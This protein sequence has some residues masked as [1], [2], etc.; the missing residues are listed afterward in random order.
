MRKVNVISKPN[1]IL[2]N[3]N[4]ISWYSKNYIFL[5][6]VEHR[7][8]LG[9][10]HATLAYPGSGLMR[11]SVEISVKYLEKNVSVQ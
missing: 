5:K 8:E 2:L 6:T 3:T 10:K 7:I 1:T 9:F 4:G 11:K